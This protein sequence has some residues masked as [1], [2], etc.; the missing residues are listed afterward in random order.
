[1]TPTL[2][3]ADA[4]AVALAGDRLGVVSLGIKLEDWG[5]VVF[6]VIAG[7][8]RLFE[9]LR[10]RAKK[11]QRTPPPP[12]PDG[13]PTGRAPEGAPR[14]PPAPPPDPWRR[15]PAPPTSPPR[16]GPA[17]PA[18]RPPSPARP[19]PVQNVE[20]PLN[21]LVKLD[22]L[23]KGAYVASEST[24]KQ[25]EAGRGTVAAGRAL[26]FT[27]TPSPRERLRAAF[28]WREVVDAPRCRR[29]YRGGAGR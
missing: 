11:Q 25:R 16:S 27:T 29:P 15:H 9:L 19:R 23:R 18:A 1:M 14:R 7:I 13:A 28:L 21:P 24:R 17:A 3:G 6:F 26:L 20:G 12:T 5:L 22:E 8:L 10:E 2:A 4:L